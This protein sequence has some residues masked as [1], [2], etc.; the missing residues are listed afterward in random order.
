M[1]TLTLTLPLPLPLTLTLTLTNDRRKTEAR[2]VLKVYTAMT[3][4][5]ERTVLLGRPREEAQARVI[6]RTL[7]QLLLSRLVAAYTDKGITVPPRMESSSLL[8]NSV[9][10]H[11]AKTKLVVDSVAFSE[12]RKAGASKLTG[13]IAASSQP[14]AVAASSQPS[15]APPSPAQHTAPNE[16]GPRKSPRPLAESVSKVRAASAAE[17]PGSGSDSG[18]SPEDD[19]P[20]AADDDDSDASSA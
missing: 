12:W 13:A 5:A 2:R 14:S 9:I 16:E 10:E 3:T 18:S 7:G 17:G 4:P 15:A 6:V 20:M 19:E 8:V 11:L 1:L